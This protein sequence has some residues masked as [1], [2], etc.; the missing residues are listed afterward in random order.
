[1]P[2]HGI[3]KRRCPLAEHLLVILLKG[4]ALGGAIEPQDG[5]DT[6]FPASLGDGRL[7]FADGEFPAG[8]MTA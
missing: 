1:M 6:D 8:L 3:S 5:V 2:A 7:L 4:F